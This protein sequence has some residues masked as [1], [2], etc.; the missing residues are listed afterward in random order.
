MTTGK[1]KRAAW[2]GK[3]LKANLQLSPSMEHVVLVKF[4]YQAKF[5]WALRAVV[6]S[7]SPICVLIP[8]SLFGSR[9][10]SQLITRRGWRA[11][12]P[13][14]FAAVALQRGRR[15]KAHATLSTDVVKSSAPAGSQGRPPFLALRISRQDQRRWGWLV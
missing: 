9:R 5:A 7:V 14:V 15:G 12:A 8:V 1:W 13:A 2:W 4:G 3:G 11:S 6:W 10:R